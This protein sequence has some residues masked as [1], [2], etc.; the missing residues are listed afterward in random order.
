M[1]LALIVWGAFVLAMVTTTIVCALV[2][3]LRPGFRYAWRFLVYPNLG[4]VL[5]NLAV[6]AY[7]LIGMRVLEAGWAEP[8]DPSFTAGFCR[9]LADTTLLLR[10]VGPFLGS[11]FGFFLGALMALERASRTTQRSS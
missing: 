3:R 9:L 10:I 5:A 8:S 4:V 1:G 2:P 6:Y 11:I 7:G